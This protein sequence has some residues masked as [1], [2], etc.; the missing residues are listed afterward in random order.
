[1]DARPDDLNSLMKGLI[2]ANARMRD[3]GIDA[4]LQAASTA[5][6]FVYVHPLQDG[7]GRLH[8]CL[9]HHVLAER[10]FT[11]PGM[12][13][14]VLSVMLD[15][16]DDYRNTIQSHSRPLMDF[17][18][19]KPTADR[20]VEVLNDTADLYRYFDCTDEAEF[21]YQCVKRT[22]EH[23]LPHEIDYLR[24]HD[25]ARRKIMDTVEM[26]DR[27]EDRS[28]SVHPAEQGRA[29]QEKKRTR[30]PEANGR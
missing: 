14:P 9:I 7:N 12:V 10:K 16:I 1:M 4:V 18:D 26:P 8:R 2:D 24:R 29:S 22:V 5:F 19:W 6:G 17:I 11:P 21:L 28:A 23:D 20:N 13:F 3:D 25:E 27:L 15:R 30:I